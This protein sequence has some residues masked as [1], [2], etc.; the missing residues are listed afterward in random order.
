MKTLLLIFLVAVA[1]CALPPA[2]TSPTDPS[3]P[4]EEPRV[5]T[6]EEVTVQ[7][8]RNFNLPKPAKLSGAKKTWA[9][10][11][12]IHLGDRHRGAGSHLYDMKGKS[13]VETTR[14]NFCKCAME[15]TC[16]IRE[17]G[18][19]KYYNY[20]GK[21]STRQSCKAY[22]SYDPVSYNRFYKLSDYKKYG[23]GVSSYRLVPFRTIAV[24]RKFIP[25]GSTVFI[26]SAVGIEFTFEGKQYSHDG[27]FFAGDTGG[28]IKGNHI[29]V[30]IGKDQ[31]SGGF[32]KFVK[33]VSSRT[34][35]LYIVKS[36]GLKELHR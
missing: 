22:F 11:Y 31:K 35:S 18:V 15:G 20:A 24:D 7:S 4:I 21:G 25:Y 12:N 29:D 8:P 30:F 16:W 1:S 36:A 6:P 5:E 3:G 19:Y 26:P 32:S 2:Q 23:S 17:K 28:L 34:F 13:L 10:W 9:T 14:R 27:F 33:S